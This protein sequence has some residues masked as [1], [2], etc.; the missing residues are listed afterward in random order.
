MGMEL[1]QE[2]LLQYSSSTYQMMDVEF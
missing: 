2:E 1:Y